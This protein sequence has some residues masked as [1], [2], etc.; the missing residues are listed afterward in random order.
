LCSA[1]KGEKIAEV[2]QEVEKCRQVFSETGFLRLKRLQQGRYWM[3][4]S[5]EDQLVR[6][7]RTN[8]K[9]LNRA[10][11]L[12]EELIENR[13][14]PRSAA[15]ELVE[16]FLKQGHSGGVAERSGAG[17]TDAGT[18]DRAHKPTDWITQP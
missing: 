10:Q 8:C 6:R 16:V 4:N 14:T 7:A 17:A 15:E 2:W 12:E 11:A 3:W 18:K 13:L 9:V 1:L 5:L